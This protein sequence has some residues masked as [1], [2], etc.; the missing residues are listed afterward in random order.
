MPLLQVYD[1]IDNFKVN[2]VVEFVGVLSVDPSLA[3]F[4][5]NGYVEVSSSFV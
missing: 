2:D 1:D 3:V 4:P 5:E